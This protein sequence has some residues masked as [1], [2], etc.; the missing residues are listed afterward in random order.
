MHDSELFTSSG[1]RLRR[2]TQRPGAL[3]WL[4][5]PGGPGIGSESL[6]ELADALDVPGTLWMVDLPGDGSNHSAPGASEPPF[7]RWPD[8]LLEAAQLLP[9]AVYVGHSTGGMYLLSV[10][11]LER[12]LAGLVLISSAPDASW[13]PRFI[14]MTQRH[15]LPQVEAATKR[16]EASRSAR[17]L[18]DVTVA[19]AE[20]NFSPEAVETGRRLLARMPYNADA[21]DWSDRHFDDVYAA[22]WWPKELPTLLISGSDDRIVWQGLWDRPEFEGANVLRRRIEGGAHFPWV[23]QPEAVSAAFSDLVALLLH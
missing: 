21:V 16:Y 11:A 18:A 1:V 10:P 14:E 7:E 19:S 4:F 12:H 13:K 23:E 3:N 8:V 2:R 20:W 17:T 5:L 6:H 9:N 15:P 22:R